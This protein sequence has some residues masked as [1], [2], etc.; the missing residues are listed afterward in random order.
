[1]KTIDLKVGDRVKISDHEYSGRT[2]L[3][4]YIGNGIGQ[5]IR[6]DGMDESGLIVWSWCKA[7]QL[8]AVLDLPTNDPT[9]AETWSYRKN[10]KWRPSIGGCLDPLT[11]LRN[12]VVKCS[13]CPEF[14]HG[15]D[16]YA[17]MFLA[18]ETLDAWEQEEPK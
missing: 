11:A 12:L 13:D 4:G 10:P 2:G 3:I 1:M 5:H 8:T 15:C 6:V 14:D 7:D 16:G 9:Q 18:C 17:D